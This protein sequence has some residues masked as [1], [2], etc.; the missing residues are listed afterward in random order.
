MS[1]PIIEASKNPVDREQS[2]NDLIESI[3]LME[4]GLSH[5][6]NAEGEKIQK[7]VNDND[8]VPMDDIFKVNN[9]V[10]N[11][12]NSVSKLEMILCDKLNSSRDLNDSG[13]TP[14]PPG[15]QGEQGPPGEQGPKGEPGIRGEVGYPGIQ[16]ERG[17]NGPEGSPGDPGGNSTVVPFSSGQSISLNI[18]TE[19]EQSII[20]IIG[21]GDSSK[22]VIDNP[23]EISPVAENKQLTFSM[24]VAGKIA[25][26]S[27]FISIADVAGVD[28]VLT[29]KLY[30]SKEPSNIFIP[31][32]EST[33]VIT[34]PANISHGFTFNE[35]LS[36][37]NPI[38]INR[39]T[40]IMV[41][42][43]ATASTNSTISFHISGGIKIDL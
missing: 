29:I 38:E 21:Y 9:S 13:S 42:A 34:I 24:P 8:G 1:M 35:N 15:P 32:D 39:N 20:A 18:S 31:Y 43:Y 10:G 30:I 16:G 23:V 17:Y 7:V 40:R 26:I 4:I 19:E 12:I 28:T 6:V 3:A 11:M 37:E 25:N 36:L 14:G 27:N 41:V 5:I 22:K 33:T 2:I